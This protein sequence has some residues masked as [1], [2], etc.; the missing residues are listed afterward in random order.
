MYTSLTPGALNPAGVANG[1]VKSRCV[2]SPE[3]VE[4]ISWK[5]WS[6]SIAVSSMRMSC[7][8]FPRRSRFAQMVAQMKVAMEPFRQRVGMVLVVPH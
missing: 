2:T 8:V 6:N 7:K 1:G 5:H 3:S 4:S